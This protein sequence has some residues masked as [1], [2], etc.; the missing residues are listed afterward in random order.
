[1]RV[2]SAVR[3]FAKSG[4]KLRIV[5]DGPEFRRLRSQAT[6]NIEFCG[7]VSD[8]ELKEMYARCRAFLMPGEEDF[9]MTAVEALASGKPVIALDKGG[10]REI[11]PTDRP[12]GGV[13]YAEPVNDLIDAALRR[14]ERYEQ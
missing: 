12:V 13:L 4:R 2:D 8:E 14:F 3:A 6:S 9:G 1:K 7:R 5:G 10:A 11:V